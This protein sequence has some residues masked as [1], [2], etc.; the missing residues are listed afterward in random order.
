MGSMIGHEITHGFDDQGKFSIN[1]KT[2][3]YSIIQN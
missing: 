1:L 2:I 3:V